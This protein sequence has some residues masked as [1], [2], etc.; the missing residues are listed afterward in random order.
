MNNLK[1]FSQIKLIF[2][3]GQ[4][5]VYSA[6]HPEYGKVVIKTGEFNNPLQRERIVREVEF[7]KSIDSRYFP[8][9]FEF[10]INEIEKRFFIIE[11]FIKSK[12]ITE[13]TDYYNSE[14]KIIELL[15]KLVNALKL[16]WENNIVHR[17]LKP[18]NILI[19]ENFEPV[20]IDLGIARFLEYESLTQ[21]IAHFGPC[22]P[23]YAA[24][25]QLLNKKDLINMRT[26]FFALGIIILEIHLGFHPFHPKKVGKGN[27]IP[28]NII[29]GYY[30]RPN[31]KGK[32]S[33]H[34]S[35]LIEKLL[36]TQPYQRFR[37]FVI[38]NK[39]LIK[40]WRIE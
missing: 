22:T 1:N 37:N 19:T 9:I 13:L 34:F 15:Y 10:E 17:D 8:R 7:L 6:V 12:K 2:K 20:I 24:P 27:S 32:T 33:I 26:D 25:E 18:D 5:K 39:F 28:E 16:L 40:H 14:I 36:K 38:L 4:K 21:T 11:K 23:I 31:V 29:N 30:V 3:G 35:I